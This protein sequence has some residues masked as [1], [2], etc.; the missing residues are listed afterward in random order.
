MF[1]PYPF[2]EISGNLRTQSYI[3]KFADKD[4]YKLILLSPLRTGF[5]D[6]I[7]KKSYNECRVNK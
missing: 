3:L 2:N 7:K 5:T 6:K 4:K 1:E